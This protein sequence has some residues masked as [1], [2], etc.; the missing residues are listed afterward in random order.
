MFPVRLLGTAAGRGAAAPFR[1][2]RPPWLSD[3]PCPEKPSS[4]LRA[5]CLPLDP[6]PRSEPVTAVVTATGA[7]LPAANFLNCCSMIA[8][9][10]FKFA[11]ADER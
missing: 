10:G 4:R 8:S 5:P 11:P 1:S 2:V 7:T 6:M 9:Q 3:G